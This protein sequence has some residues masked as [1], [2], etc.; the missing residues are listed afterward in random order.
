MAVYG[1]LLSAIFVFWLVSYGY[2]KRR[3]HRAERT[4][5]PAGRFVSVQGVKLHYTEAGEGRPVVFLHGGVLDGR[6]FDEALKLCAAGGR[7]A[8]AFDRPGY[9]HSE[10]PRG[11][12]LTPMKQAELIHEALKE[13]GIE[14]PVIVGHSWSG[15]LA[16]AYALRYPEDTA[17]IVTLGGGMYKEGYPAGRWDP[18]SVLAVLPVLGD[19]ALHALLAALGPLAARGMLKATFAPEPVPQAYLRRA[20]ALWLR[21]SQ[22]KANREDVLAFV[23]AAE[24]LSPRYAEIRVPTVIVV[25]ENDPFSTKEHS[26]RLHRELAGSR[27][28]VLPDAAHMIPQHHPEETAKAVELVFALESEAGPSMAN[29]PQEPGA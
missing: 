28:M 8:L 26:F 5:R 22:F 2:G 23:P 13:L 3:V 19:L 1:W 6:D 29:R 27:L 11:P 7:R 12:R 17:G 18:V 15:L 20:L 9:G 4:Y 14:R 21:P 25:G 24:A 16:L 10:R